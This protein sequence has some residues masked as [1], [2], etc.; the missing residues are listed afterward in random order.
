MTTMPMPM[1]DAVRDPLITLDET[2]LTPTTDDVSTY[3]HTRIILS[4]RGRHQVYVA[5]VGLGLG[6]NHS[7]PVMRTNDMYMQVRCGGCM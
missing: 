5:R 1:H 3:S 7:V 4:R 2:H 6:R